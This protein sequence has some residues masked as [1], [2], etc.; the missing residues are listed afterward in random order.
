VWP[1]DLAGPVTSR[2]VAQ[3]MVGDLRGDAATGTHV[4]E[5]TRRT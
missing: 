5:A 4:P 2:L 3:F 1:E